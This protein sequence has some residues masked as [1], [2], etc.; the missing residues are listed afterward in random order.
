ME[1]VKR[2][3]AICQPMGVAKIAEVLALCH[4][5]HDDRPI[6]APDSAPD[7]SDITGCNRMN[8]KGGRVF[9]GVAQCSYESAGAGVI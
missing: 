5:Q 2:S 3:L 9:Q 8:Y 6:A 7:S 1:E 4:W